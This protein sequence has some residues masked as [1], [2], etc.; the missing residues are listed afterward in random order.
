MHKRWGDLLT[1][2]PYYNPN[3]SLQRDDFGLKI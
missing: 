3:L 2:D 1:R